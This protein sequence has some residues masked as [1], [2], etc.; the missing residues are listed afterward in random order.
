MQRPRRCRSGRRSPARNRVRRSA[1][2][3]DVR[4]PGPSTDACA[5]ACIVPPTSGRPVS[6]DASA[7][8]SA[9]ATPVKAATRHR[10]GRAGPALHRPNRVSPAHSRGL[11]R[12]RS[13]GPRVRRQPADV[14]PTRSRALQPPSSSI[15]EAD[16]A[17]RQARHRQ[18]FPPSAT[19]E[20]PIPPPTARR[21]RLR[22]QW[23]RSTAPMTA[24]TGGDGERR[25]LPGA[26]H[27]NQAADAPPAAASGRAAGGRRRPSRRRNA[28][29]PPQP[30]PDECRCGGQRRRAGRGSAP[31]RLGRVPPR[32]AQQ[33]PCEGVTR[34]A[35]RGAAAP[36][37]CRARA[38]ARRLRA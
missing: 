9:H 25:V 29:C 5:M 23:R 37:P 8:P 28:R 7:P 36:P 34:P 13:P 12:R 32:I 6:G 30:Q 1:G 20:A 11:P 16:K 18:W 35:C 10:A 27:E 22:P 19:S 31:G 21:Q 33:R 3:A 24:S 14:T 15:A 17:A 38:A 2:R 26:R 4:S